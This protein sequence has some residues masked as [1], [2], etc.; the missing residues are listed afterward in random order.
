MIKFI[1]KVKNNKYLEIEGVI[2][3]EDQLIT[4]CEP[5]EVSV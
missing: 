3:K 4:T 5:I 2:A 1:I